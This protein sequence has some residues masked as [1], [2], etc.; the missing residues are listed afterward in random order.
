MEGMGAGGHA[1][2]LTGSC[3]GTHWVPRWN[4]QVVSW[5]WGH[6]LELTGHALELTGSCVG[7]HLVMRWNSLGHALELTGSCVGTHSVKGGTHWSCVGTRRV[8]RW[9]S[10]GHALELT[11]SCVGT[12]RVTRGNSLCHASELA[13]SCV[14]GRGGEGAGGRHDLRKTCSIKSNESRGG[15]GTPDFWT[16]VASLRTGWQSHERDPQRCSRVTRNPLPNC[17]MSQLTDCCRKHRP[18]AH[19]NV[20]QRT[21]PVSPSVRA[22]LQLPLQYT[23][24][25]APRR[26]CLATQSGLTCQGLR[27]RGRSRIA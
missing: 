21:V 20:Q 26:G 17:C 9:N 1:L 27:E 6:A 10:L 5:A 3:V 7:T 4:S 22:T 16:P 13:Q 2:E 25:S 18:T 24:T 11:G 23:W 19:C 14:R 12:H 8:M 15:A